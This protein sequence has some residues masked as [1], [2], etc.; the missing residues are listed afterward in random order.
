MFVL[1]V[2][3]N[4]VMLVELN[5]SKKIIFSFISLSVLSLYFFKA[6]FKFT[7][8]YDSVIFDAFFILIIIY[9]IAIAI[10]NLKH[11]A[12]KRLKI[13]V[14]TFLVL[15][16]TYLPLGMFDIL[17]GET[18]I[19]LPVY[20][21]IIN[22]LSVIFC[23]F[24]LY[25]P[26]TLKNEQPAVDLQKKYNIT[27]REEEIIALIQAGYSNS[28]ISEKMSISVSTVEKHIYNIYQK[29]NI[30]NRVQLINLIQS[31]R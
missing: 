25:T 12:D 17:S 27:R 9:C 22:T 3:I 15:A 19:L 26:A 1:P 20:F 5:R 23:M 18:G 29:L 10:F 6:L 28:E 30:N 13:I 4:H 8:L 31:C 11:M 14:L 24:F 7:F 2:L 21:F 16:I